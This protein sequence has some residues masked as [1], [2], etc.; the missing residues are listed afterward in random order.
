M[1]TL[2]ENKELA[3]GDTVAYRTVIAETKLHE[4][5]VGDCYATWV[6]ICHN[7]KRVPQVRSVDSGSTP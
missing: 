3:I 2:N 4:R 6:A 7:G 1:E 5:V